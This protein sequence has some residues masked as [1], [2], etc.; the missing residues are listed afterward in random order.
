MSPLL[1]A[2]EQILHACLAHQIHPDLCQLLALQAHLQQ[3]QLLT[4]VLI[5]SKPVCN[6]AW[7][8]WRHMRT[9]CASPG[10]M[11]HG[12]E[13]RSSAQAGLLTAL[14]Y[15]RAEPYLSLMKAMVSSMVSLVAAM[16][17][18]EVR[19]T[20]T[21]D[22]CQPGSLHRCWTNNSPRQLPADYRQ[23]MGQAHRRGQAHCACG[24]P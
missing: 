7:S 16:T 13:Q 18:L 23:A 14:R 3:G 12:T 15:L 6:P 24:W 22:C 19:Y 11:V 1:A 9:G 4:F 2:H 20:A 17:S 8:G 5:S 21:A 10:P